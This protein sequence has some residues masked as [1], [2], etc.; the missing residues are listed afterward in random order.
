MA[1]PIIYPTTGVMVFTAVVTHIHDG[2]TVSLD[3]DLGQYVAGKADKTYGFHI[4]R[5][6]NHLHLHNATR[7][8]GINA[9]ELATPE[10]KEAQ[11][12]LV[13]HLPIGS[14]VQLRSWPM[15]AD[16]YGRVLGRLILDFRTMDATDV[17]Q[18]MVDEGYAAIYY[19]TGPKPTP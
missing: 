10:G 9:P 12:K 19:G 11:L 13:E 4:Y 16:K 6:A 8:Y 18:W 15:H 14:I 5:Q 2:D 7:L 1:D 17:N 3:I